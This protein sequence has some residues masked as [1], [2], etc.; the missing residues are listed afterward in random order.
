MN[1]DELRNRIDKID[2]EVLRL[3]NERADTAIKLGQLKNKKGSPVHDPARENKVLAHVKKLN[4]GPLDDETVNAIYRRI[5]SAC[6]EVQSRK[7]GHGARH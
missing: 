4:N 2:E 1:L 3:L 7:G 6:L 5:I